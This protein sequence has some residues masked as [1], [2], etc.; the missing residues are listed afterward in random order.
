MASKTISI[1]I[2]AYE[3]LR[4]ARSTRSESFSSVIKRATWPESP[5]TAGTLLAAIRV[6]PPVQEA[7]LDCL[8]KGQHDDPAPEDAWLD[9]RTAHGP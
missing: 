3:R 7:E 1:D 9:A 6:L 8:K 2:E 4:R 5:R